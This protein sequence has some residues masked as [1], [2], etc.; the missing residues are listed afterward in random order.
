MREGYLKIIPFTKYLI[1][2]DPLSGNKN[3]DRL[4]VRSQAAKDLP[5]SNLPSWGCPFA[6]IR[7]IKEALVMGTRFT[8]FF[9]DPFWVG[10]FER[11]EDGLLSAAKIIFGSEPYDQDIFQLIC[12]TQWWNSF[13]ALM[14]DD[15]RSE[16]K[17]TSYK[18]RQRLISRELQHSGV[19][20]K[21]MQAM[22]LTLEQGKE[23]RKEAR[24][25]RREEEKEARFE[26]RQLKKRE[27]K[28]GH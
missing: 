17:E 22:K 27:K 25:I 28:R 21:A 7:K 12:D 3:T 6:G 19:G 9:E 11:R 16:I 20:T 4:V 2:G 15:G 14:P 8:V 26:S 13:G 5:V 1:E 24:I 18:R 10:V 23:S